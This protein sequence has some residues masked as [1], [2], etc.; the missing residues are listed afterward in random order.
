MVSMHTGCWLRLRKSIT[1]GWGEFQPGTFV[2]LVRVHGGEEVKV[3][4]LG[5]LN[6]QGTHFKFED[7]EFTYSHDVAE[8]DAEHGT[9]ATW[10][11]KPYDYLVEIPV[12][13]LQSWLERIHYANDG[14]V[15]L[16][17]TPEMIAQ[18]MQLEV[19]A[20]ETYAGTVQKKRGRP[21]GSKTNQRGQLPQRLSHQ[22]QPKHQMHL[23]TTPPV[24]LRQRHPQEISTG[25][26]ARQ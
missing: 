6:P 3:N 12:D 9:A 23:S 20:G 24:M 8:L 7:L 17:T 14:A 5:E 4:R 26:Q 19:D 1:T 21:A 22:A 11:A 10:N 13:D 25:R 18:F 16:G 15:F 2:K